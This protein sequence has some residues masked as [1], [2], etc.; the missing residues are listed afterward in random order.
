MKEKEDREIEGNIKEIIRKDEKRS[1]KIG[2]WKRKKGVSS[3]EVNEKCKED[4]L[5]ELI[6]RCN[7][8][9]FKGE[10]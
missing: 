3:E 4:M 7:G 1:G 8:Y 2:W 10:N 6:R 5:K 9:E